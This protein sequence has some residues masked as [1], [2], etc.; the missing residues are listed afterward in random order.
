MIQGK[1]RFRNDAEEGK[2]V[3]Q[4]DAVRTKELS[5]YSLSDPPQRFCSRRTDVVCSVSK[6]SRTNNIS[7]TIT[8]K[9]L[10]AMDSIGVEHRKSSFLP[11]QKRRTTVVV[12]C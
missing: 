6:R 7:C 10:R 3:E 4:R 5:R 12:L 9:R 8:Y 11:C 1:L 2:D